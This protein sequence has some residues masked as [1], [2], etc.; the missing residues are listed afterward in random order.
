MFSRKTLLI[1]S[2][3]VLAAICATGLTTAGKRSYVS[4]KPGFAMLFIAPFQE[5]LT[6][7]VRSVRGLW[8]HY[9]FLVSVAKTNR[10]LKKDLSLALE[11]NNRLLETELSNRRLRNLLN[12]RRTMSE[13]VLVAEVISKDPCPWFKSIFINKGSA[14]GVRKGLPVVIPEGV[15]GLVTDVS[16]LYAKVILIIDRNS[17]VDALVQRTRARGIIKGDS[18]RLV[19]EYVLR[20]HDIKKGDRVVSSGLD[21]VFPKGLRVGSV[22]DVNRNNSGVFQEV[23]VTPCVDFEKLEEVLVILDPPAH[24][25]TGGTE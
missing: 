24:H 25:L 18:D 8:K 14:D 3:I 21:S 22:A 10:Q 2:M 12:F 23:I 13:H 11:K 19:F 17:A 16:Q 1:I 20:K 15:T 7:S 4:F 9:F 5:M 6:D